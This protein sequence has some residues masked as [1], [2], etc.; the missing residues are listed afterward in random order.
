MLELGGLRAGGVRVVRA[1]DIK[2]G[3]EKIKEYWLGE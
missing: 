2:A 1:G 3:V